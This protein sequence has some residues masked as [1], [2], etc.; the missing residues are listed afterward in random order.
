MLNGSS[1]GTYRHVLAV[2]EA[3]TSGGYAQLVLAG[4]HAKKK[5]KKK[6]GKKRKRKRKKKKEKEKKKKKERKREGGREKERRRERKKKE[7]K[8]ITLS[9][10]HKFF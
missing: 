2:F 4:W 10:G 1:R 5:M 3:G 9:D 7:G 8:K 6:R